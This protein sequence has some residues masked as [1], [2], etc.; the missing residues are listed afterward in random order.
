[1]DEDNVDEDD[2]I[3][4]HSNDEPSHAGSSNHHQQMPQSSLPA[5]VELPDITVGNLHWQRNSECFE[6]DPELTQSLQ[7]SQAIAEIQMLA[8]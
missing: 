1:M 3:I 2:Q 6:L 5:P 4:N 7:L 8:K